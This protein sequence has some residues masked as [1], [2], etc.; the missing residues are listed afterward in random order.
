MLGDQGD[1]LG[2]DAARLHAFLDH[3]HLVGLA[4][5]AG[6]RLHIKGLKT[7][8]VN[9]LHIHALLFELLNRLEAVVTHARIGEDRHILTFAHHISLI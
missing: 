3:H 9:K 7:Y 8:Q 1:Q 2:A 4:D 5:R 6:N